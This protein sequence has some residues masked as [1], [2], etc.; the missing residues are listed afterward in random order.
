MADPPA[1]TFYG[2][3]RRWIRC[4]LRDISRFGPPHVIG[5]LLALAILFLQIH[6]GLISPSLSGHALESVLF[7]YILVLFALFLIS[8]ARAP[9]ALERQRVSELRIKQDTI[10]ET[11]R[12]NALLKAAV[13]EATTSKLTPYEEAQADLAR[14]KLQGVPP[15]EIETLKFLLQHGGAEDRIVRNKGDSYFNGIVHLLKLGLLNDELRNGVRYWFVNSEFVPALKH[16]LFERPAT[17]IS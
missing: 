7:P 1:V 15:S 13:E 9:L 4:L 17:N 8:A 5:L 10:E 3:Y 16:V 14:A 12:E 11:S 2:Y 6:W